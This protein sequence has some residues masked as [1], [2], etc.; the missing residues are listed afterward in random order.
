MDGARTGLLTEKL[1]RLAE[2]QVD[3]QLA[4]AQRTFVPWVI[5]VAV[6]VAFTAGAG[7]AAGV[8]TMFRVL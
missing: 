6:L 7:L 5:A 3:R 4:Q 2:L 8:L 1:L